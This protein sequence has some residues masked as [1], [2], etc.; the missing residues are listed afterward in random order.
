MGFDVHVAVEKDG[1]VRKV[2]DRQYPGTLDGVSR[3][4]IYAQGIVKRNKHIVASTVTVT[5]RKKAA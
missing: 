3:A 2:F 4:N 5:K 1:E